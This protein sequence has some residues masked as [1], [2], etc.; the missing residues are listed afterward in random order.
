MVPGISRVAYLATTSEWESPHARAVL[1]AARAL[2][3]SMFLA[4]SFANDYSGAFALIERDR[5]DAV[6]VG[7]R[8]PHWVHRQAIVDFLNRSRV[9]N[10]HGYGESAELGGLIS[11]GNYPDDVWRRTASYVDRIL[12]GAKPGALPIEQPTRFELVVNRRTARALG[13]AIPQAVLLRADRL[14]E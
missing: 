1:A 3:L 4:Q 2:G 11:Y 6:F 12:K 13:I 14:I 5:P 8:F 7:V 10:A 9:P